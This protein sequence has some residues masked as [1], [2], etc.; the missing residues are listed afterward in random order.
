MQKKK[1]SQVFGK[2]RFSSRVEFY[3]PVG[4]DVSCEAESMNSSAD[5]KSATG[6]M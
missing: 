4:D 1:N 5:Y 3:N 2:A 6:L